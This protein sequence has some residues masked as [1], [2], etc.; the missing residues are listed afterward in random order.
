MGK[1]KNSKLLNEFERDFIRLMIGVHGWTYA[2]TGQMI[3][4]SKMTVYKAARAMRDKETFDR[5]VAPYIGQLNLPLEE[6]NE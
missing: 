3:G 5:T 6:S 4:R 1:P 2:Q